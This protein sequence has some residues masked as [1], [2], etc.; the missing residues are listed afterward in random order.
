MRRDPS[1]V[2]VEEEEIPPSEPEAESEEESESE[3]MKILNRFLKDD[4]W[5]YTVATDQGDLV[6]PEDFVPEDIRKE[7]NKRQR[8]VRRNK[9]K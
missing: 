4:E 1:T 7:Y 2:R 3:G 5:Y 9:R 6:L 8:K